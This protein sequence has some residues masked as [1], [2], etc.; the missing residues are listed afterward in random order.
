[1]KWFRHGPRTKIQLPAPWVAKAALG[2]HRIPGI[3]LF[4][5]D[6]LVKRHGGITT[7]VH[8]SFGFWGDC[9][10]VAFSEAGDLH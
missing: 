2:L 4:K 8:L 3:R 6:L 1:M 7:I 10:A 5:G 9:R